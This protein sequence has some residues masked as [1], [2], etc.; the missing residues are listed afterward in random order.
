MHKEVAWG[1]FQSVLNQA[2]MTFEEFK[3]FVR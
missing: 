2:V 1:T 3:T